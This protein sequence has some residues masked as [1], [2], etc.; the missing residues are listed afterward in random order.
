MS[1][2]DDMAV[3]L[4]RSLAGFANPRDKDERWESDLA[5]TFVSEIVTYFEI[6]RDETLEEA[7]MDV[8]PRAT[9]AK[10]KDEAER[11]RANLAGI[12]RRAKKTKK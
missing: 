5:D 2:L 1:N 11:L 8:W 4:A 10:P 12:I 6:V 9:K 3:E 7:A